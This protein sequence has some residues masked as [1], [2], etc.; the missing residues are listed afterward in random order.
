MLGEI[1]IGLFAGW[2]SNIC[3]KSTVNFHN[4]NVRENDIES[5][6]ELKNSSVRFSNLF[7]YNIP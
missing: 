1:V 5:D 3:E 2:Q 4:K 6:D 7:V